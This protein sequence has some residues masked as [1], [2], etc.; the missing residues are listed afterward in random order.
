MSNLNKNDY[1]TSLYLSNWNKI[2]FLLFYYQ[3][4]KNSEDKQIILF[5]KHLNVMI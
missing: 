4:I 3:Y 1:N 2:N 5:Q